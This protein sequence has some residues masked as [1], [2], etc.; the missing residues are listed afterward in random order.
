MVANHATDVTVKVTS[1]RLTY[2]A[3]LRRGIFRHIDRCFAERRMYGMGSGDLRY[4]ATRTEESYDR[5]RL[6]DA[7]AIMVICAVGSW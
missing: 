5:L 6:L 2:A 7:C 3:C 4:V 1:T